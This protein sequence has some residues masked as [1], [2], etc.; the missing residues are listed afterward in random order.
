MD[1]DFVEVSAVG[2][3]AGGRLERVMAAAINEDEQN[4]D[5]AAIHD[6][7]NGGNELRSHEQVQARERDHH[8]NQRERAV[9]RMALQNQA[10]RRGYRNR[11]QNEEN[12]QRRVHWCILHSITVLV[13]ITFAMETGSR[14]FQPKLINWS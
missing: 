10:H 6:D 13:R 4:H 8:Y 14:N 2:S 5:G 9:N 1:S 7:L 11:S 12:R 3:C